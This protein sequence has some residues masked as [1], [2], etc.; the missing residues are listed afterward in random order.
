MSEGTINRLEVKMLELACNKATLLDLITRHELLRAM[1]VSV[2]DQERAAVQSESGSE[3]VGEMITIKYEVPSAIP[4]IREKETMP[5]LAYQF[6]EIV[7]PTIR[8]L[9][10]QSHGTITFNNM[11]CEVKRTPSWDK[12]PPADW[13]IQ[14]IGNWNWKIFF[15][16][17][18]VKLFHCGE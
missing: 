6:L 2:L 11:V 12:Y 18:N 17:E 16:E 3:D 9:S 1:V 10:E 14:G 7:N 4:R 5:L 15:Q 13:R 8:G